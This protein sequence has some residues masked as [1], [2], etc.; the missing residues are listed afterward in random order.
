MQSPRCLQVNVWLPHASEGRGWDR[1]YELQMQVSYIE[2]EGS[3]QLTDYPAKVINWDLDKFLLHV[4]FGDEQTG[5]E[6]VSLIE[7]EWRWND[8]PRPSAESLRVALRTRKQLRKQKRPAQ[9]HAEAVPLELPPEHLLPLK[10]PAPE[11]GSWARGGEA[12]DVSLAATDGAAR[13]GAPGHL[14]RDALEQVHR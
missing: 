2:D 3:T 7:D 5:S 1:L 8:C 10:R 6:W 11:E 9:P 13:G 14:S 4:T 12:A